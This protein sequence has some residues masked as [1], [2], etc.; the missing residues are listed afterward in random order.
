MILYG[1][2]WYFMVLYGTLDTLDTLDLGDYSKHATNVALTW[3]CFDH[4]LSHFSWKNM[5]PYHKTKVQ[6]GPGQ[7][8][9]ADPSFQTIMWSPVIFGHQY[10]DA[11]AS[12]GTTHFKT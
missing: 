2:L 6:D 11:F 8:V 1:T 7:L 5:E 9:A 10:V 12:E 3:T 4:V